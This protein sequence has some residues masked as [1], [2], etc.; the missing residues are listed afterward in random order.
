ME[1]S[2]HFTVGK[3]SDE[4]FVIQE[5]ISYVHPIYTN[6]PLNLYLVLGNHS[7][8][9]IDTGCGLSPLKPI[10]N[11]LI[12]RRE[13][14]VINSHAHWDHILGNEEFEKVYIHE[15]EAGIVSN[16]YNLAY[17]RDI[18][19]KRYADRNFVIPPCDTIKT[20]TD[21]DIFD[22]G[23]KK[24][25]VIHAPGHSPGSICL[26]TSK[27][28]LF[29]GDVAYYGDQFLPSR[30]YIPQVLETLSKLIS[31]CEKENIKTLYPS[32]QQT[33]CEIDL[34]KDLYDGISNIDNLWHTRK[35]HS[36][37]YSWIIDDPKHKRFRYLISRL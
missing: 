11:K 36:H 1:D 21:E 14:F 18:F 9:L 28:E 8:A 13:L 10:V 33:P 5:N 23:G 26:L 35:R 17:H 24:L 2:N 30:E 29:T 15:N 37:F 34:F 7:A 12:N 20:I 3:L 6:D 16:P 32:H 19:G 22:L 4:L 27:N 25:E 31:L